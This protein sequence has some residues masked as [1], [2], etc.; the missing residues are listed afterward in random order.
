MA[1]DIRNEKILTGQTQWV[2]I[3]LDD[4]PLGIEALKQQFQ[5]WPW[6]ASKRPMQSETVRS[7]IFIREVISG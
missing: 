7:S 6:R 2:V 5:H 4:S 3:N 1:T